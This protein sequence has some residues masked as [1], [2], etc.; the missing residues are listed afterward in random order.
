MSRQATE[1]ELIP[2]GLHDLPEALPKGCDAQSETGSCCSRGAS[3]QALPEAAPAAVDAERASLPVMEPEAANAS[4]AAAPWDQQQQQWEPLLPAVSTMQATPHGGP[5]GGSVSAADISL[6]LH[7]ALAAGAPAPAAQAPQAAGSLTVEAV[8]AAVHAAV[9]AAEQ[10]AGP[11]Q[12]SMTA[13]PPAATAASSQDSSAPLGSSFEGFAVGLGQQGPAPASTAQATLQQAESSSELLAH[14]PEG[15]G[16]VEQAE[17][18][19]AGCGGAPHRTA[20]AGAVP[21]SGPDTLQEQAAVSPPV[22][23]LRA[24]HHDSSG[25]RLFPLPLAC[26]TLCIKQTSH[27]LPSALLQAERLQVGPSVLQQLSILLQ[28]T[29]SLLVMI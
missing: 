23:V 20:Q 10:H 21:G 5:E 3:V 22:N 28:V 2:G 6:V 18:L 24:R 9:P 17:R 16:A 19:P 1:P 7:P 14:Q 13:P 11:G 25:V 29:T 8:P 12:G 15:E 4:Q 26:T 27:W